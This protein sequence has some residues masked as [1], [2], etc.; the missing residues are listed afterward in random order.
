MVFP[1]PSKGMIH[2]NGNHLEGAKL[3]L[4]D[5]LGK[6]L[7]TINT[8][9]ANENILYTE[10]IGSGIYVLQIETRKGLLSKKISI[11]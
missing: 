7:M 6:E 9:K 2:I 8:L 3:V 10:Q 5:L 1:N 11:E 4:Y